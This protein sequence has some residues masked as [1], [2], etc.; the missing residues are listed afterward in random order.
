MPLS[1]TKL[2]AVVNLLAD[3]LQAHAAANILA[4]EARKRGVVVAD[5]IASSAIAPPPSPPPPSQPIG[6]YVRLIDSEHVGIVSEL[7]HETPKAWLV[8]KP[9]DGEPIW[10]PKSQCQCHGEDHRGR[11]IIIVPTWLAARNGIGR[12]G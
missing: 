4:T 7:I 1:A 10:L 9:G 3:P 12:G 8:G 5:L 2:R 6:S 11:V